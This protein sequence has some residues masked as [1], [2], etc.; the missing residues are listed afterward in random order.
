[1]KTIADMQVNKKDEKK[2]PGARKTGRA[3][4]LHKPNLGFTIDTPDGP[5]SIDPVLNPKQSKINKQ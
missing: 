4:D 1:M 5:L 3:I 2:C